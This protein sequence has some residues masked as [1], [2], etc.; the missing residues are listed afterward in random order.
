MTTNSPSRFQFKIFVNLL[1]SIFPNWNFFDR[2]A[3]SFELKF[4]AQNSLIWERISFDQH[5]NNPLGFFISPNCSMA[6]AQVN[7]LEHFARDIQEL[8]AAKS[9]IHFKDLQDLTTFKMIR[10]L[11]HVKLNESGFESNVIQFK[12]VA[13]NQFEKVDIY[14]S[15]LLT[16]GPE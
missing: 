3:Y 14:I 8:Q 4:K 15:D 7:L 2:I 9:E 10:S 12:I 6:L 11:L 13:C 16:L 1:R 5:R